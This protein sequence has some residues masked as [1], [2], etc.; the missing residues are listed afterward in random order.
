MTF[1][2]VDVFYFLENV[3]FQDVFFVFLLVYIDVFSHVFLSFLQ[4]MSSILLKLLDC[5]PN[6]V[7]QSLGRFQV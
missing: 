7:N 4:F 5:F 3:L 6:A 2:I 1:S